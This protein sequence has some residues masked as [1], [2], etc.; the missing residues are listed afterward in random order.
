[1][2]TE[3]HDRFL[4]ERFPTD[5]ACEGEV[6]VLAIVVR[7]GFVTLSSGLFSKERTSGSGGGEELVVELPAMEVVSSVVEE[8]NMNVS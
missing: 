8:L 2:T 6:F 7:F 3:C 4:A 1:M 5:E